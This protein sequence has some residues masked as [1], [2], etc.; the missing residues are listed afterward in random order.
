[1]FSTLLADLKAPVAPGQ[2]AH[3]FW[4]KVIGKALFSNSTHCVILFRISHALYRFLPTRPLAFFVRM[5]AVAWGGTDIHPGAQIGPGFCL[6]HSMKIAIG[7][8]VVIGRDCRIAHGVTIGGDMGR[9]PWDRSSDGWPV[10]GDYVT[11]GVDAYV[12]GPVTIGD[13]AIIGTKALVNKD[14]PVNGIA[15]GIPARVIKTHDGYEG[16]L[17]R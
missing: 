11:I 5:L 12:V 16:L 15:V 17:G 13:G 10:I 1:M 9:H 7:A 4:A 8:G 2:P 6:V 14:V 3:R